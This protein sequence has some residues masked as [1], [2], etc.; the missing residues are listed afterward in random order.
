MGK[1]KA[2]SI[3]SKPSGG[4]KGG[5][6]GDEGSFSQGFYWII[7]FVDVI[8]SSL[9]HARHILCEKQSKL[10]EAQNSLYIIW[11]ILFSTFTCFLFSEIQ[12]GVPF[13][14]VAKQYSEDAARSGGLFP[15]MLISIVKYFTLLELFFISIFFYPSIFVT[16][17]VPLILS[18][19]NLQ[20]T[21]HYH[22]KLLNYFKIDKFCRWS[23]LVWTWKNGPWIWSS[24]VFYTCRSDQSHVQNSAWM[25]YVCYCLL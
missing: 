6:G 22:T 8:I 18:P 21:K 3:S 20:S 24:C 10:I 19:H 7:L 1:G 15:H 11:Y 5:K 16:H 17:T 13:A 2:A 25:A 23:R 12:S 9:V 4:K 14:D